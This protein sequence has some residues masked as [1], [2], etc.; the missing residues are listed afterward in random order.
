MIG[1]RLLSIIMSNVMDM[2]QFM[3]A[4]S[5]KQFIFALS[6]ETF[7]YLAEPWVSSLHWS[8]PIL[9]YSLGPPQSVTTPQPYFT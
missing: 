9:W 4:R 7:F 2:I 6:S 1:S 8:S 3:K 5:T